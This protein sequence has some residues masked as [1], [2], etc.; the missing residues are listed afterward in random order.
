MYLTPPT[1]DLIKPIS[2]AQQ[3]LN[4]THHWPHKANKLGQQMH[5]TPPTTYLIKPISSTQQMF[6][7]THHWSQVNKLRPNCHCEAAGGSAV[8]CRL[9]KCSWGHVE[10]G[11]ERRVDENP[12]VL[13]Y[14]HLSVRDAGRVLQ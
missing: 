10:N 5:L 2:S 13:T 1:T 12:S 3:M 9:F 8:G 14:L 6:N 7:P 11:T 4:P